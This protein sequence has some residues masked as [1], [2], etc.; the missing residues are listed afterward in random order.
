MTPFMFAGQN[1]HKDAVQLL[2]DNLSKNIDLNTRNDH[3]MTAL[4]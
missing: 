4:S 1:G 3:G 2:L